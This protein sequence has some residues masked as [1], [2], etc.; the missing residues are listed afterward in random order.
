VLAGIGLLA[1]AATGCGDDEPVSEGEIGTT[2]AYVAIVQWQADEQ[3]P[4][5]DE[6]G[7]VRLPVI[8]VVA[9]D[10]E[11][12][13]VGVQ[14]AV[15]EATAATATVRFADDAADA[16]A[17]DAEGEPVR[18][19]GVLLAVGDVPDPAPSLIV[20]VDRYVVHD[21]GEELTL[22]IVRRS[23]TNSLPDDLDPQLNRAEVT[24]ASPR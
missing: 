1:V 7:E 3:E 24:S 2:D 17:T 11:T 10:G 23:E 12:V 4:V 16:F 8:F 5:V 9:A 15:A 18:D 20:D 6:N 22:G 19:D 21:D 14:A 13:D